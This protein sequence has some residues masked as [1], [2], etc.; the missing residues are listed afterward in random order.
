[1]RIGVM[2][3]THGRLDAM[4]RV[5]DAMVGEHGVEAIVHLGDDYADTMQLNAH[6]RTL[7]A[8]PGLFEV[9][10]KVPAIAH[11]RI[12]DFGGITFFISHTPSRDPH[13]SRGDPDP[14]LAHS[15]YGADVLLHGHTHRCR[16][17]E[18]A[19][20]LIIVNPGH[21]KAEED[22][23]MPPTF[24]VIDANHSDLRVKIIT[25]SGEVLEERSFKIVKK[26]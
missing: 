13:D 4:Q 26:A 21:L 19:D 9:A 25:T 7:V 18:A 24:A 15:R 12:E 23:G 6:G 11:R 10:W 16:V 17:E 1:M 2:S 22:R 3:D 8:V 20:G 5:A 14:G